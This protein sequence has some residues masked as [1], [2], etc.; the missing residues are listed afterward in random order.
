MENR[1]AAADVVQSVSALAQVDLE[2][3]RRPPVLHRVRV[4]GAR[5]HAALS[6]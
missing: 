4:E 3:S 5:E 1:L 6:R 2:H